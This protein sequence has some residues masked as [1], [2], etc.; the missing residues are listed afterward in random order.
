[1]NS[2]QRPDEQSDR[3]VSSIQDTKIWKDSKSG[4]AKFWQNYLDTLAMYFRQMSRAEQ[5]DLITRASLIMTIGGSA[6]I[7][8]FFY[9]FLPDIVRVFSLPAIAVGGWF[10]GNKVVT[11]VMLSRFEKYLNRDF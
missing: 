1:M 9:G 11:P 10:V 7:L 4:V 5:E 2:G 6:L 3:H 8:T